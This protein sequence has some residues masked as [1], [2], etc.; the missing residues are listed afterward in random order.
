MWLRRT[1]IGLT[2]RG[3]RHVTTRTAHT[4][5]PPT[6]KPIKVHSG[7]VQGGNKKGIVFSRLS[8]AEIWQALRDPTLPAS[9]LVAAFSQ[10]S[11]HDVHHSFP[12]R[13]RPELCKRLVDHMSELTAR[14]VATVLLAA[15]NAQI[16]DKLFWTHVCQ[17]AMAVIDKFDDERLI[18][19]AMHALASQP[20]LLSFFLFLKVAVHKEL[21]RGESEAYCCFGCSCIITSTR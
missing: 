13:R 9:S 18:S 12:P 2:N 20:K 17:R 6:R 21:Q 7:K 3:A 15:N 1:W 16:T 8:P 5:T 14:D 10:L 19:N 4:D 11:K